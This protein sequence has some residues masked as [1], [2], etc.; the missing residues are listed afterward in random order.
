MP[1]DG[2]R[3]LLLPEGKPPELFDFRHGVS[4]G[5]LPALGPST[6]VLGFKSNWL[7]CWNGTN[8][9]VVEE[10]S[11]S[12]FAR[13]GAVAIVASGTRPTHAA[14]NPARQLV[15]WNE[16]AASNSVFLAP[17]ATPGRRIALKGEIAGVDT[18]VFS[19]DGKYLAAFAPWQANW[20]QVWDRPALRVWN[21]DTG[22]SVLS[23]SE[24]VADVA[25][26][27]GGRALVAFVV[28]LGGAENQIR[29]YDLDHPDQEPRLI[30]GKLVPYLLAV[31]PDGRLVAATDASTVRLCDALTG[32]WVENLHGQMDE[33]YGLAFSKDGQRL[34][35]AGGGREAIKLWDVGTRQELLN[36]SGTGSLLAVAW[37]S[38]D[39]DTILA[40]APWQAWRAPSWEEIAAAEAKEKAQPQRP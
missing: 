8:Q 27:V 13:L 5:P 35:S 3:A 36:L 16:P 34:I 33:A 30:S 12:Q 24:S 15:A 19:G 6:N 40:G 39:G 7:C 29:F 23:L 18:A 1:L 26:A 37:W 28:V 25:F 38:P 14:F 31:S 11:G 32:K 21:V 22:Q 10:W 2:A 17:L 9:I 20:S 4:L